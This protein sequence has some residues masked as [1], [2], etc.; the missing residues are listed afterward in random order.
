MIKTYTFQLNEI[1]ETSKYAPKE[2]E[3]KGTV[4]KLVFDK[5]KLQIGLSKRAHSD[6][7]FYLPL[8]QLNN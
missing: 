6:A 1:L 7:I 2:K 8:S 3:K 5:T 4:M